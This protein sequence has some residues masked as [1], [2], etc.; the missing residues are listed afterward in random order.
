MKGILICAHGSKETET[1]S[2]VRE[3][4]VRVSSI[5]KKPVYYGF[6]ASEE[7]SIHDVLEKMVSDG[8]DEIDVIP[9]FFAPGFITKKAVPKALGLE[10]D[11]SE[12]EVDVNGKTV[13]IRITGTFGDHPAMEEVMKDVLDSCNLPPRETSV[14]L[15]GHGSKDG[16]NSRTVEFNAGFVSKMGYKVVCA[17]NE[18]QSP[19]VQ[20]AVASVLE[21]GCKHII[22][23][24]MFVSPSVHSVQEIPE[25]LGIKEGRKTVIDGVDLV[26]A[27][28]VGMNPH[29]A[30]ILADR[31]AGI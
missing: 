17:Y 5:L 14:I 26:Y 7:P 9:L 22:A 19:T 27:E 18:M 29:I 3:H 12:G 31:A 28:E 15:I 11:T 30:D 10:P 23:I 8:F 13:R 4:S 2:A 6:N 1:G 20:E 21:G 25:K 24:P 16:T